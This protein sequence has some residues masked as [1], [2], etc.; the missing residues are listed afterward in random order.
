MIERQINTI[1]ALSKKSKVNRNT[2]S[3]LLN[4][5]IQPSTNVMYRLAE[6]LQLEPEV[7]GK[8]FFAKQLT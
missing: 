7:A 1:C 5:S 8:I 4:G 6:A 2:L 3:L